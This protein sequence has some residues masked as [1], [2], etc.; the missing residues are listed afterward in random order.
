MFSLPQQAE[1]PGMQKM[2]QIRAL[3][4]TAAC[5]LAL[6]SCGSGS[7]SSV[8]T[9]ETRHPKNWVNPEYIGTD[10]FHGSHVN[11]TNGTPTGAALFIRRC[12]GCH[13]SDGS[14]KIGPNIQ[15]RTASQI[16]TFFGIVIY[17]KWQR[18]LTD[19]NIQA[20]SGFLTDPQGNPLTAA[21]TINGESCKECHGPDLKGGIA[22]IS[23]F[24]CHKDADGTVG[25]ASGWLSQKDEPIAYHGHYAKKYAVACTT[26]HGPDL[27]GPA[28]PSCYKCHTG[29]EWNLF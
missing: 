10:D 13:G 29:T 8:F 20:I 24:S 21:T 15:G 16:K 3:L 4:L 12:A 5:F 7:P 22:K 11:I 26:C 23:C 18:T 14:G 2:S 28:V 27:K 6:S 25:H 1:Q 19:E 17:M 9:P